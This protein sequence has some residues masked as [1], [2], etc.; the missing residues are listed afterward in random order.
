MTSPVPTKPWHDIVRCATDGDRE[1]VRE[2][3]LI[4]AL[5]MTG[6]MDPQTISHIR[7]VQRIFNLRVTGVLDEYTMQYISELRWVDPDAVR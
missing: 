2:V 7:G 4:L 6:E 5:P 3:Q 1:I